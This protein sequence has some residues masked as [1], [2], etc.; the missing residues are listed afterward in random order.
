LDI[1]GFESLESNSLEQL[2]INLSNEY[3]QKSFNDTVF[4]TELAEYEAEG[5]KLPSRITF[6]DNSD[7]IELIDGKTGILAILDDD[8]A[9]GKASDKSYTEKIQKNFFKESLHDY[10]E[11]QQRLV[12]YYSSLRWRS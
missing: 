4:K 7:I 11:A 3:L 8:M 1:A 10:P 5:V 9:M 12:V 6:K 2:L